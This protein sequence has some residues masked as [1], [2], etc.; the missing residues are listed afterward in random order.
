MSPMRLRSESAMKNF[1]R[2]NFPLALLI[3]Q[4]RIAEVASEVALLSLAAYFGR[5]A[6]TLL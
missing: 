5:L 6:H 1:S 2:W 4:R 3:T